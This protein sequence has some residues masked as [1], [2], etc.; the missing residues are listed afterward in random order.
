[1]INSPELKEQIGKK[2]GRPRNGK[3]ERDAE[4]TQKEKEDTEKARK[5][6]AAFGKKVIP[7]R[8][9]KSTGK[10]QQL[11]ENLNKAHK[12]HGKGSF[13][14]RGS[15]VFLS[16]RAGPSL[17]PSPST[18]KITARGRIVFEQDLATVRAIAKETDKDLEV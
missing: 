12:Q 1:M 9:P 16:P 17:S 18:S 11:K 13:G 10:V 8:P 4:K 5:I 2:R 14:A 15:P 6:G 7:L 3:A